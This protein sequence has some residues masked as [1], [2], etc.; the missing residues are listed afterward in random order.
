MIPLGVA[1]EVAF[2]AGRRLTAEGALEVADDLY[3]H[4]IALIGDSDPRRAVRAHLGR[5]EV[6]ALAFAPDWIKSLDDAVELAHRYGYDDLLVQAALLNPHAIA[7]GSSRRVELIAALLTELPADSPDRPALLAQHAIELFERDDSAIERVEMYEALDKARAAGD[8]NV[9]MEVLA[10]ALNDA[11]RYM[12]PDV[13]GALAAELDE[14][15][16]RVGRGRASWLAAAH[17]YWCAV[18]NGQGAEAGDLLRTIEVRAA[19]ADIDQGAF[20]HHLLAIEAFLDGRLDD[21]DLQ[22]QQALPHGPLDDSALGLDRYNRDGVLLRLRREQG[23]LAELLPLVTGEMAPLA[24]VAAPSA[25]A[26]IAAELGDRDAARAALAACRAEQLAPPLYLPHFRSLRL[27][28][29]ALIGDVERA[30]LEADRLR[31]Y[32]GQV[33]CGTRGSDGAVD[34]YLG[35]AAAAVGDRAE[36]DRRLRSALVIHERLG[37][38]TYLARTLY[39]RAR[40]LDDAPARDPALLL[41]H[42]HHLVALTAA[43]ASEVFARG[44]RPAR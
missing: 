1:V 13:R 2:D 11:N 26:L 21:A 8:D 4:A 15:A 43:L 39:D 20:T 31:P 17:R 3:G 27:E 10:A 38:P 40:L 22:L 35:L 32:A 41:A 34:R 28:A 25:R 7:T 37:S 29:A 36:C 44:A 42:R 24:A 9:R 18:Q 6:R 30:Q 5:A 33:L 16:G 12:R 19:S 23:R 14:L